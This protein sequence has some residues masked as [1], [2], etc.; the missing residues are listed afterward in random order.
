MRV[1]K[2]RQQVLDGK[3]QE[4]MKNI[5]RNYHNIKELN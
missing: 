2:E 5:P 4:Y 3:K 1:L